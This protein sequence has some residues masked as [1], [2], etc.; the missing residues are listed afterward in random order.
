MPQPQSQFVF[1]TNEFFELASPKGHQEQFQ[2]TIPSTHPIAP[3]VPVIPQSQVQYVTESP[4]SNSP[5]A[6]PSSAV[7]ES[8]FASFVL[9][10]KKPDNPPEVIDIDSD[11]E[12][13][14]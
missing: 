6:S 14:Q 7:I 13:T 11:E 3:P 10:M 5:L 9:A 4:A 2:N 12:M 8:T 1:H